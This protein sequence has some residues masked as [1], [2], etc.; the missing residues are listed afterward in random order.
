MSF[1]IQ[2]LKNLLKIQSKL[3]SWKMEKDHRKP[4]SVHRW[5][6]INVNINFFLALVNSFLVLES[7][8]D[9]IYEMIWYMYILK[10]MIL[11]IL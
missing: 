5:L 8:S 1:L 2:K 9:I 3:V 11:K 7:K 6:K 4:L 10:K